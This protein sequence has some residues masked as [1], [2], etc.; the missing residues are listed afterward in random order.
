MPET[1][2]YAPP[3]TPEMRPAPT[4]D[5]GNYTPPATANA[6]P[7]TALDTGDYGPPTMTG[8]GGGTR[9]GPDATPGTPPGAN[10]PGYNSSTPDYS[11]V[12]HAV[13]YDPS[14]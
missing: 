2:S 3:A 9:L 1:N 8:T 6:A 4:P 13:P 10:S 11:D 12:V 14:R 7:S 5:T